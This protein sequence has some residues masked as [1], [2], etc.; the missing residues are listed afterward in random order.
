M[1]KS[2]YPSSLSQL[3]NNVGFV[4][5]GSQASGGGGCGSRVGHLSCG[6]RKE[7]TSTVGDQSSE[8]DARAE[9][10]PDVRGPWAVFV[11]SFALGPEYTCFRLSLGFPLWEPERSLLHGGPWSLSEARYII[12]CSCGSV[13][14]CLLSMFGA[15][16]STSVVT[17]GVGRW[18]VK[19]LAYLRGSV[20]VGSQIS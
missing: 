7:M 11:L 8:P 16:G 18:R 17:E 20:P 6:A 19:H 4:V 3:R 5:Q 10:S 13:V 9:A 1:G 15:L 12:C 2:H 14:D